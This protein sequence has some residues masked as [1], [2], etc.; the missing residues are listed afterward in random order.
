MSVNQKDFLYRIDQI[1]NEQP[2]YQLGHDG[3]D[4]QCD[5]IGLVIGA[6]RRAGGSWGGTHGTN[7]AVRN[8]MESFSEIYSAGQ[9]AVGEVVYK[10]REPDDPNYALPNKYDSG[11]DL[12]DYYHIG[13]V[14]STSPLVITHMTSPTV[15]RDTRVGKWNYHGR[16]K[17]VSDGGAEPMDEKVILYGGNTSLPITMR[18]SASAGATLIEQVPQ[19]SQVT[20]IE[21]GSDWC[22]VQYNGRTGY[23]MS[24]FITSSDSNPEMMAEVRQLLAQIDVSLNKIFDL[25]GRG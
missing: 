6:I 21:R 17:R 3:S 19:N 15:K 1:A 7:Y 25:I 20:L 8:E 23:V 12:T 16:L 13:V 4:G 24:K 14:T 2:S 11:P 5:C 9:L 18:A 22:K 10:G